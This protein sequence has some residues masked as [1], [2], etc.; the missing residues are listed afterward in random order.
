MNEECARFMF[1]LITVNVDWGLLAEMQ[2][3]SL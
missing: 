1:M 2:K 3:H